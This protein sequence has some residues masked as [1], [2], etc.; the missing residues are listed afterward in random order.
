MKNVSLKP[1]NIK[2]H[3]FLRKRISLF[4]GITVRKVS[5]YGVFSGPYFPAFGLNTGKYGPEETPYF[6]TFH[7]VLQA[8]KGQYCHNIEASQLIYTSN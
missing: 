4:S 3:H 6:D 2:V 1:L 7:A 5:K 8:M